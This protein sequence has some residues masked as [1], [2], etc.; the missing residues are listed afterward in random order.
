MCLKRGSQALSRCRCRCGFSVVSHGPLV[1]YGSPVLINRSFVH[2]QPVA[3]VVIAYNRFK[4]LARPF[5][6][7]DW[8]AYN[9]T[10]TATELEQQFGA[11][12][13]C[14]GRQ[15]A[16]RATIR[17]L[18][19][20]D[21]KDK[22]VHA[23]IA[24]ESKS[25]QAYCAKWLQACKSNLDRVLR[26]RDLREQQHRSLIDVEECREDIHS[27][28]LSGLAG[29]SS[30]DLEETKSS[31]DHTIGGSMGF[32]SSSDGFVACSPAEETKSSVLGKRTQH[33]D[34]EPE[35]Q[36]DTKRPRRSA[37]TSTAASSMDLS[38]DE[39]PAHHQDK[40]QQNQQDQ[41]VISR[42]ATEQNNL[43]LKPV[44][45]DDET[46]DNED[47]EGKESDGGEDVTLKDGDRVCRLARLLD[48]DMQELQ[49]ICSASS[50]QI[51]QVRVTD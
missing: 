11:S 35:G 4:T 23:K 19:K 38:A 50:Q 41:Q 10:P 18:L 33:P 21:G 43:Q 13:D 25:Q 51:L 15:K 40:D 7:F 32:G 47:N 2:H 5:L 17:D 9:R 28:N 42:S 44:S 24:A 27:V 20:S 31:I 49:R 39:V 46:D 48:G 37:P 30:L 1:V 36:S 22:D 16:Y 14:G 45:A 29:S 26:I 3:K 6:A 34:E 8:K 12:V